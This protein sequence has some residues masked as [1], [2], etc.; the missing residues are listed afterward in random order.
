MVLNP[1]DTAL[2]WEALRTHTSFHEMKLK[3]RAHCK[4]R[5]LHPRFLGEDT[6]LLPSGHNLRRGT[7]WTYL[8]TKHLEGDLFD[9]ANHIMEGVLSVCAVTC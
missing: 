7:G 1:N 3:R 8:A 6:K 9:C 2:V 5:T 4:M